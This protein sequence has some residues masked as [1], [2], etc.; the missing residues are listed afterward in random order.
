MPK[1]KEKNEANNIN[2]RS[3]EVK[4]ILGRPPRW[5]IRWG[6][7]LIFLLI[8]LLIF[9]SW[10]FSYPDVV[11]AP[12]TV[13]TE[14]PPARIVARTSGKIEQLFVIDGQDVEEGQPLAVIENP[15]YFK[16]VMQLEDN[17]KTSRER[18]RNGNIANDNF[19]EHYRLGDIQS[20]YAT[21]IKR[22]DDFQ[23]FQALNYHQ[24]TIVMLQNEKEKYR[25]HYRKLERQRDI[26]RREY[27]L[28]LKQYERDSALYAQDVIPEAEL[29]K[30]ETAMLAKQQA[31]EQTEVS[32]SN[33]EIQLSKIDQNI[34]ETELQFEN[35]LNQYSISLFE[36]YD[37][38]EAAI[39]KWKENYF[40]EAPVNGKVSF[41]EYWSENQYVESGRRVMT[42][43]SAHEGEMIGKMQLPFNGAGKVEEG[44]QVNIRFANYPYLE[45][46][47]VEG[48]VRSVSLVP[49]DNV[50]TVEVAFPDGLTT[51]Y[52]EELEFS[53]EMQ[54]VGEIITEDTRL[55]E[56]IVRPLRYVLNKHR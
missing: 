29:E 6:I 26:S 35:Q 8:V 36:A 20:Y 12:I 28:A 7:T 33:A 52:G 41:T 15:A 47:M 14:N 45:Y 21:F 32:L 16:H 30:S 39:D 50:Y 18:L 3:E 46:G 19:E 38:L 56:R 54:G 42:V 31:L 55:L 44:Q 13:T 43:I 11:T 17:L 1:N 2:L 51:F 24:Q 23:H 4:E 5:L 25:Q 40:L 53:R 27:R 49:E 22:L 10:F 34:K 48:E 37:N 9:G